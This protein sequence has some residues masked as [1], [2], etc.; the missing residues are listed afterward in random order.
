MIW[1]VK[2]SFFLTVLFILLLGFIFS[3]GRD[4]PEKDLRYGLTFSKKK[5][6]DLGFDWKKVYAAVLDELG[7]RR[8]RLPAYWDEV[9]V[10]QGQWNWS[11]L[12]WQ[13]K[14]AEKRN[15]EIILAI[16]GRLPR[17]PEC[18]F[19]AWTGGLEKNQKETALLKY[20]AETVKRYK[21]NGSVKYWQVENEPFLNHFGDCPKPDKNFLDDEIALVRS[22]DSRPII[23]TD[24]GEL[25]VWIPA[26]RRADVFGTTM[27]RD[28]YSSHLGMYIHYPITPGFFHFKKNLAR[29]F[30]SPRKWIVIELQAEPWC[31][32]P[33]EEATQAERNRTMSLS[34]FKE[35]I[36]FSS[37]TGFGEFYL[38][39]AEWWYW[40][41]EVNN[42]PEIWE[43][44][45]ELFNRKF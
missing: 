1:S 27:Y 28:T 10:N 18:H 41:R 20:I 17:W 7:A 16:G 31:P 23:I 30:A 9:E 37:K 40:E 19:P 45:K 3:L 24:S 25:S 4:V 38:W 5:A 32:V 42:N 35:M 34:K 21:D 29:L 15:A 6:A 13:V 43:Y 14:E 36:D 22:L 44:A 26:A 11:D 33:F 2:K 12:D 39:G 8:I